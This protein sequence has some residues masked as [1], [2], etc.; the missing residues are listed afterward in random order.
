MEDKVLPIVAVAILKWKLEAVAAGR[1]AWMN[2]G[3]GVWWHG[4]P[5]TPK[6]V[7]PEGSG[8]FPSR[9]QTST[10][11]KVWKKSFSG[12]G[13]FLHCPCSLAPGLCGLTCSGLTLSFIKPLHCGCLGRYRTSCP[14]LREETHSRGIPPVEAQSNLPAPQT[15]SCCGDKGHTRCRSFER[16]R[17]PLQPFCHL[18]HCRKCDEAISVCQKKK[19]LFGVV[20]LVAKHILSSLCGNPGF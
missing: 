14:A 7:V 10:R 5:S 13:D 6:R 16:T 8:C 15:I 12:G 9:A 2:G 3:E 4:I 11:S 20:F 1:M 19:N 17:A 18:C